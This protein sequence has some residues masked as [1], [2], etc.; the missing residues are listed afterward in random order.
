MRRAGLYDPR[1]EHDACGIGFVADAGGRASREIVDAALAALNRVR[2]R[3]AVAADH[4]SGDGAGILLPIPQ[5]LF[6]DWAQRAGLFPSAP[7]GV[8]MA[9][10][11]N[12]PGDDGNRQRQQFR[13]LLEAACRQEQ[14]QVIGWRVVPVEPE[15]L[16][17]AARRS[18]PRIEQAI[19]STA[20]GGGAFDAEARGYCARKRVER[21]IAAS[22]LR[23]YLASMSFLSLTY[24]AMCAAD[25]LAA[26]YPDL[27]DPRFIAPFAI[28][29]QRY[30]TNTAPSWERAQPFRM[31]CHNGEINTIQGNINRMHAREGRLGSDSLAPEAVLVPVIDETGSDSAMLDNALELLVQG[32]R[33]VRQALA[34]LVPEAWEGFDVDPG[35]R[36][37]YRYHACLMEPWDGPAGLVF[38]D[39]VRV[40]A[41]LDRNGLRPLRYAVC[42]DG[43]V[44][45]AS[46]AGAVDLGG[47]GLVRRAKLGPGEMLCVDPQNGGLQEN[48]AIKRRLAAQEPYGRWL[49]EQLHP[50]DTGEPAEDIPTDLVARQAAFGYTKEEFTY[51]LRPMASQGKEPIFSMG[52][53]TAPSV[54]AQ[55]PRLLYSYFKQRFAQVTNPPIDHLRERLVM[56]LRTYLGPP[57]PLLYDGPAAARLVQ[58][59]S[60]VLY[61]A[62]LEALRSLE[63]PFTSSDLDATFPVADGA[64]G[65]QAACE[66]LARDAE[67]AVRAGATILVVSDLAAS[68]ARAP[69]P[70]L[71]A[72]GTVHHQLMRR[73]LRGRTSL[74]VETDEAREVHHV[75]CLLGY[76]A[77]AICP[78]LGLASIEALASAGHLKGD[79]GDGRAAQQRYVEALEDGTLKVMAKMGIS[80][81]DGYQGAQIFE[82][83]GLDEG[84]VEFAFAG[85]RSPLGGATFTDLGEQVLAR[86]ATGFGAASPSLVSPGFF[87]HHKQGTEYHATNPDV[88]DALHAAVP[89]QEAAAPVKA[90]AAAL[91]NATGA[92]AKEMSA[93]HAL[94]RAVAT[95]PDGNGYPS[96]ERFARLV[97]ERPPTHP[98][99]L[100]AIRPG[101]PP[102]PLHEVEPA[103]AIVRRFSTGAMSHGSI[104]AE[105]HETIAIAMNRL[106]GQSNTG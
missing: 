34:M 1:F 49:D 36:D 83:I 72:V 99:D 6:R 106:G 16:G 96:Y 84:L 42:E 58:L 56:S 38:T 93:A 81:L 78:R 98:R 45:C 39:G 105:A 101:G 13:Q 80:T 44:A 87:K 90:T 35:L 55:S 79:A 51:V 52:D 7:L 47:H 91:V 77:Q 48:E 3:G 20:E 22:R 14:L 85:S 10:L 37:F 33:D 76:G 69:V 88:V 43:L 2:H 19:I 82:I 86:H 95:G 17:D 104:A 73:G 75:V 63:A 70:A 89:A 18:A 46:E 94:Q 59:D 103:S 15:A 71:L 60:F 68:Q 8:A 74:V 31:L 5:S 66:R 102:L 64:A 92:A 100:L 28:F 9:F 61:P 50:A 53:D 67:Q 21:A 29:H 11:S 62:G 24:K 65:L 4:R 26:F 57:A 27:R 40:G 23:G 12:E 54:L 97:N 32:G 41:A 25:Q 30:S